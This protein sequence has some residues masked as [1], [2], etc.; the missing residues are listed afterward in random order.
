[1]PKGY[2]GT[3]TCKKCGDG[4]RVDIGAYCAQCGAELPYLRIREA[5]PKKIIGDKG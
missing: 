3:V 1:M 5:K 2:P 4:W